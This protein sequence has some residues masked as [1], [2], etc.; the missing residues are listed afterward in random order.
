MKRREFLTSSATVGM[1]IAPAAAVM[2][3]TPYALAGDRP[4]SSSPILGG[5]PLTPPAKGKIRVA[6]A[7][8]KN[9]NVMDMAGP[10]EVFQDVHVHD[11]GSTHDAQMPFELY[12]V[13]ASAQPIRATGGLKIVPNY[14]IDN[15]PSPHLVVVPASRANNALRNWLAAVA[16][17]TDVTMSVCT[18]A[19]QLGKAGLL[20]GLRATTH[21]DFYDAFENDFPDV[22]LERG[23]RFVENPRIAT[24]GGLTAGIDLA[25][26][27]V[28]RYFSR[29]VA[30]W[31]ADYMEYTGTGWQV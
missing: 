15:A 12:T 10:W 30:Q 27:V 5:D 25:L 19:F 18:G 24:A 4:F 1:A 6:F 21:H 26:R 16:P 17:E 3:V 22:T 14:T 28:E 7:I 9:T 31:T 13:A 23:M 29:D 20:D 2:S 8:A 11:R